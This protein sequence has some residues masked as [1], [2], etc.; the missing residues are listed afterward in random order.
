MNGEEP[1]YDLANIYNLH[2]KP[3]PMY[4]DQSTPIEAPTLSHNSLLKQVADVK[5]IGC[6]SYHAMIVDM[7]DAVYSCGLNNYGQLGLG[8]TT[9]RYFFNEIDFLS[10]KHIISMQG[11]YL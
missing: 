8:D 1:Q 7:G 4:F 10:N 2:I 5:V 9:I 6:G 3:G 11:N